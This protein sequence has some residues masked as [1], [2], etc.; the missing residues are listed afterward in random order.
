[1]TDRAGWVEVAAAKEPVGLL[2]C[3]IEDGGLLLD[4]TLDVTS[5][6]EAVVLFEELEGVEAVE[7][8]VLELNCESED[9]VKALG[10]LVLMLPKP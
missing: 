3:D 4:E 8:G 1:V 6:A 10:E 2:V 7:I 5:V 9:D